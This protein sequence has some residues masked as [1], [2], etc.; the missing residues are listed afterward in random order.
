MRNLIRKSSV[1]IFNSC[2]GICSAI[3]DSIET[4]NIISENSQ[5]SL[6]KDTLIDLFIANIFLDTNIVV[7]KTEHVLVDEI[8]F[9]FFRNSYKLAEVELGFEEK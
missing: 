7:W 6:K 5:H 8:N 4:V 2:V 3:D 1:K 9:S